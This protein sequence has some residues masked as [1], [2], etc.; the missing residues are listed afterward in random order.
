MLLKNPMLN[1]SQVAVD[2][3]FEDLSHFSRAFK[4]KFGISPAYY[5]KE[6]PDRAVSQVIEKTS[7]SLLKKHM[8]GAREWASV[9]ILMQYVAASPSERNESGGLFQQPARERAAQSNIWPLKQ[10]IFLC[11]ALSS[12][13]E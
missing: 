5:R 4:E 8:G 1:V 9:G 2:C 6:T 3:G 11:T 13:P 7:R 12:A 10:S